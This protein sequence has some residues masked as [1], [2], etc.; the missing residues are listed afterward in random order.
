MQLGVAVRELN[1]DTLLVSLPCM[2]PSCADPGVGSSAGLS[3]R[4]SDLGDFRILVCPEP[5]HICAVCRGVKP[6]RALNETLVRV[7]PALIRPARRRRIST[8]AVFCQVCRPSPWGLKGDNGGRG[9][10]PRERP[11]HDREVGAVML[12]TSCSVFRRPGGSQAMRA[13]KVRRMIVCVQSRCQG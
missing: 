2:A 9:G 8:A 7:T 3:G 12:D 13:V 4:S 1:A 11:T 6:D 10:R 5:P